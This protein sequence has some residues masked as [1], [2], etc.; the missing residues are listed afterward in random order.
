MRRVLCLVVA[1]L[2][3]AGVAA[4]GV[5]AADAK[6]RPDPRIDVPTAKL[7]ASL[8]CQ[9]AVRHARRTPILLVTGTGVDGSEAWPAG[10]QPTLT[11]V[12]RR[13]SCYVNFPQHTTGDIQVAAE[14]LVYAIREM[15]RRAGR[16]IAIYGISQGGLLP[17]WA[18]TYWPSTRS[19]VTDVVAVAGTQHGTSVFGG[20]L[21]LCGDH[22][23]FPAAA[24]QQ[25]T[26]ANLQKAIA[27][28]PDETPGKLGWTTVRSLT[29]EIVQ[30]V[31]GPH[32]TSALRGAANVVIQRV[33]PGRQ[34]S[35]IATGVDSVTYAVL[36]DAIRH[37]GPARLKRLPK[38]LCAHPFAPR[39]DDAATRASI[40][41]LYELATPRTLQGAD[42]GVVLG[43][44]PPV[45]KYARR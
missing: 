35:H 14:Y 43:A 33:C 19:L 3:V 26:G 24:W 8:H 45:R 32:P 28:Y 21:G 27:R 9:S 22:C 42:G 4:A 30:P 5:S 34:V 31:D 18:L 40:D 38:H 10:L 17:R 1:L 23:M 11:V 39:L 37:K 36:I 41:H 29:D 7:R 16:K 25:A 2:A 6:P 44:E 13:P 20:L 15:E 12:A